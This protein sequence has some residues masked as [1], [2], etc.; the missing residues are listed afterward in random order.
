LQLQ[1]GAQQTASIDKLLAISLRIQSGNIY[2]RPP[3]DL[4]TYTICG[5]NCD[6]RTAIR[7]LIPA[8]FWSMPTAAL[9]A[10]GFPLTDQVTFPASVGDTVQIVI[11][12]LTL[13]LTTGDNA[14]NIDKVQ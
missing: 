6:V 2:D 11:G 5:L 3:C 9:A 7:F 1:C 14:I 8:T 13:T 10:A 12:G 4:G